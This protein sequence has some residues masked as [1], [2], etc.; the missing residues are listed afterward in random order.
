MQKSTILLC[1]AVW[2]TVVLVSFGILVLGE[3]YPQW[4]QD[5]MR[6]FLDI[7]ACA[8]IGGLTIVLYAGWIANRRKENQE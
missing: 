2:S 8:L 4:R 3:N 5:P 1:A 6:A 7:T